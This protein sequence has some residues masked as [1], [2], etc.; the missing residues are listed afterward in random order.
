MRYQ[1]KSGISL[2]SAVC[3]SSLLSACGGGGDSSSNVIV[4]P[5]GTPTLASCVSAKLGNSATRSV[6]ST[7][8]ITGT[9]STESE[10]V[11][12]SSGKFNDKDVTVMSYRWGDS[13]GTKQAYEIYTD[14]TYSLLADGSGYLA[15]SG[16]V[17]DLTKKVGDTQTLH[18]SVTQNG[19]IG[20][21]KTLTLKFDG[22]E[23]LSV[24]GKTLNTCRLVMAVDSV[25]IELNNSERTGTSTHTWWIAPGYGFMPIKTEGN[26]TFSDGQLPA[27]APYS[28]ILTS[29]SAALSAS[30]RASAQEAKVSRTR[31]FL[32]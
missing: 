12:F 5:T 20:N 22:Q 23:T 11:S 27:T 29:Y 14:S 13:S 9:T 8:Y 25:D 31:H 6:T 3:L 18:Y 15:L 2:W 17:I 30:G 24:A 4:S 10:A 21:P 19:T 16:F 32:F 28:S 7:D 26:A 1:K